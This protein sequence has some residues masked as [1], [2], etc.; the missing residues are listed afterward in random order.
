MR[1]TLPRTIAVLVVALACSDSTGSKSGPAVAFTAVSPLATF[2]TVS[3]AL[4]PAIEVKVGDSAGTGVAN[5]T[6]V[7][8]IS[9]PGTLSALTTVTDNGGKAKV[10]LTFSAAVGTT[11]IIATTAGLATTVRFDATAASPAVRDDW[12]TVGH[13]GH[14]SGASSAVVN[15]PFTTL[16]RY[17]PVP[18]GTR[19][20]EYVN[21][22]VAAADGAYLQWS[23]QSKLG[24]GYIG[25]TEVDRVSNSGARSWTFDGGY[26]ANFGNWISIWG[27]RLVYQDDGIGYLNTSTGAKLWGSGV[28]WW[29]ETLADSSGLYVD[30]DQ[31]YDGPGPFVAL[32][33]ATGKRTWT[34]NSYG[35]V[36]GDAFDYVAGLALANGKL[37]IAGDY[38]AAA[39]LVSPPLPGV[40]GFNASTGAAAG[41]ASTKPTSK[42]SA[43]STRLYLIEHGNTLVARAQ[44]DLHVVWSAAVSNP[45]QQAPLLA[46]RNVLIATNAGV[47]SR[48]AATGALNWKSA[49]ITGLHATI[50]GGPSAST[51][52]A[53]ALGSNTL[54]ATSSTDG[55][56]LLSLST[57]VELYKYAITTN[58][59][60]NPVLI[61]DPTR[62]SILYV[63]DYNGLIAFS[64]T[65]NK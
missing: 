2:G 41:Y 26:D 20:F 32:M 49:T 29:G 11:T 40:Y 13:D 18:P 34:A 63:L 39:T 3:T 46:N 25:A 64:V 27:T 22:A 17:D 54:I 10:T 6:V 56:H 36:R 28:D 15:G 24:A 45:T 57:G 9:G 23:A 35:K 16:W 31:H 55:I 52:L 14:R 5:A 59:V 65:A 47:E 43:D 37:F 30:Q 48:N 4:S 12:N 8:T 7:W 60:R 19:P 53:A 50:R 44:S 1:N 62:G 58:A 61:N 38:Y 42:L 51:T 21:T 33:D